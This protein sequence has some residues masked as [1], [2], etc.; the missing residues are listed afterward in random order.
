[1]GPAVR[2]GTKLPGKWHQ[3]TAF[4]HT[5]IT[6]PAARLQVTWDIPRAHD[7]P[8]HSIVPKGDLVLEH[9]RQVRGPPQP[10]QEQ[11]A[12]QCSFWH[13]VAN[14]LCSFHPVSVLPLKWHKQPSLKH[15]SC[16]SLP[17]NHI[18]FGSSSGAGGGDV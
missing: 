5:L 18:I 7:L 6:D 2:A 8:A 11:S 3:P 17:L 9:S 14:C 4:P 12:G 1:M 13:E 10:H 15:D 16:S